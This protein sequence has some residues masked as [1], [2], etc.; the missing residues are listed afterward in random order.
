MFTNTTY[1]SGFTKHKIKILNMFN[2][3]LRG[4]NCDK[5]HSVDVSQTGGHHMVARSFNITAHC[6][7]KQH[8]LL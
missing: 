3:P 4:K 2:S 6:H 5:L 1:I 7:N 8:L